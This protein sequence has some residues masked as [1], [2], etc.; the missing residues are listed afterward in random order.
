MAHASVRSVSKRRP[1]VSQGRVTRR[2]KTGLWYRRRPIRTISTESRFSAEN[3]DMLWNLMHHTLILKIGWQKW[4][5]LCDTL[6]TFK[7][8]WKSQYW[9]YHEGPYR[10][11]YAIAAAAA[12]W[13]ITWILMGPLWT[14]NLIVTIWFSGIL[15]S[16]FNT[17]TPRIYMNMTSINNILYMSEKHRQNANLNHAH[18]ALFESDQTRPLK[19]WIQMVMRNTHILINCSFFSFRTHPENFIEKHQYFVVMLLTST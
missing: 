8:T 19:F 10:E 13:N 3:Y 4:A 18:F 5:I 17:H 9:F 7:K 16:M 6:I 12:N 14:V 15:R 2:Y 1:P 11:M